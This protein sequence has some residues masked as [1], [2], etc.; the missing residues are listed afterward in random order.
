M[1]GKTLS[2]YKLLKVLGMGGMSTVYLGKDIRSGSLAALK[3]LKKAY[4]Q[5]EDHL[6]RFFSREINTAK[7]LDHK[8]IV[9]LLDSG[10]KGDTHFLVYEYIEG[11]SLDRYLA[12]HKKLPLKII[13]SIIL[14]TL[15]ALSHAHSKGIVHRDI[16]PQNILVTSDEKVKITDFGIAKAL[17]ST[18]ITQTG[19]FMG[20]PSY[21]SPEQAEGKKTDGRSDLYSLG[22]ILFE[23]LTGKL[24]F[25]ADTPWAIVH[26][27]IYDKPPDLS[28][29]LKKIPP[30]LSDTVSMALSKKPSD[31]F[32][33]AEEMAHI[34][35]TKS[36]IEPTIIK[37][38]K[39]DKTDEREIKPIFFNKKKLAIIL[40]SFVILFIWLVVSSVFYARG[41]YYYNEDDYIGAALNFKAAQRMLFPNSKNSKNLSLDYLLEQTDNL[42]DQ[43]KYDTVYWNMNYVKTSFPEYTDVKIIEERLTKLYAG[44]REE[45]LIYREQENFRGAEITLLSM[46]ALRGGSDSFAD[47][48]LEIVVKYSLSQKGIE[49]AQTYLQDGNYIGMYDLIDKVERLTPDYSGIRNIKGLINVEYNL[50]KDGFLDHL[51][52]ENFTLCLDSLNDMVELRQGNDSYAQEKII[53]INQYIE[54]NTYIDNALGLVNQKD[55]DSALILLDEAKEITPEYEKLLSTYDDIKNKKDNYTSY[56]AK[57]NS[58]N[59]LNQNGDYV[60][61]YKQANNL[62]NDVNFTTSVFQEDIDRLTGIKNNAY[63][64]GKGIVANSVSF[65]IYTGSSWQTQYIKNVFGGNLYKVNLKGWAGAKD[66]E[67]KKTSCAVSIGNNWTINLILHSRGNNIRVSTGNS[68]IQEDR[69]EHPSAALVDVARSGQSYSFSAQNRTFV[70]TVDSMG[71]SNYWFE[72]LIV[73]IRVQ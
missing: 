12:E 71:V 62:L 4:T 50:L 37:K 58:I 66:S 38:A 7:S 49:R 42:I 45:Y 17:S 35:S 68:A 70:L 65:N 6:K 25:K 10:K 13:N 40:T 46:I 55:F 36:V 52:D 31:R 20:S 14:Q 53:V 67:S 63:N 54:V 21:I 57:I 48:E 8:N 41:N 23:M 16:K 19:M 61:A 15:A 18:T 1:I 11:L 56:I 29:I 22:V 47:K 73:T 32:S 33:S 24:P 60:N 27:H 44:K 51:L 9:K 5:D 64:K 34:I 39:T 2:T 59:H 26:K 3:V 72:V 43:R 69:N 30:Y 28:S